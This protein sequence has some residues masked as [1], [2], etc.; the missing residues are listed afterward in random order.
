MP[1]IEKVY[2]PPLETMIIIK[3]KVKKKL[4][5]L[6]ISKSPGPDGIHP[7]V[8]KEVNMLLCT[9]LAR[10]FETSNE[11]GLLPYYFFSDKCLHQFTYNAC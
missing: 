4:D 11:T 2:V 7:R 5:K 3:E 1:D 9:S 6:K 10:I 8:L